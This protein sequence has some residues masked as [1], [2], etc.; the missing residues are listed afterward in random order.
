MASPSS[1]L[2]IWCVSTDLEAEGSI[3]VQSLMLI[4]Y[5]NCHLYICPLVYLGEK[6][7]IYFPKCFSSPGPGLH[8]YSCYGSATSAAPRH[9]EAQFSSHP[10]DSSTLSFCYVYLH[11][12][13]RD[14]ACISIKYSTSSFQTSLKFIELCWVFF[15]WFCK[16]DGYIDR[17]TD[18]W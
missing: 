14:S 15:N 16:V 18:R 3:L 2:A 6:K 13:C 17:Q 10:T 8:L 12:F 1:D 5:L 9:S 7:S 4:W 11:G